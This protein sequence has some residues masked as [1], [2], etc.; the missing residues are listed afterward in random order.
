M[1]QLRLGAGV[2]FQNI[3]RA[4]ESALRIEL[5]A[6]RVFGPAEQEKPHACLAVRF[7]TSVRQD[8]YRPL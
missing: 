3:D 1:H 4:T 2:M 8:R 6:K 5:T 7:A